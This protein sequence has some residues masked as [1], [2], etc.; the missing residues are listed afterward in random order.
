[1]LCAMN[2]HGKAPHHFPPRLMASAMFVD[3]ITSM[4]MSCIRS[5]ALTDVSN[6]FFTNSVRLNQTKKC[7]GFNMDLLTITKRK[8][9]H[10]LCFMYENVLQYSW[11]Q[12][13]KFLI[14]E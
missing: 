5:S 4:S 6:K 12:I 1:M 13:R 11:D 7:I 3:P 8:T 9:K 14:I 10:L 2:A